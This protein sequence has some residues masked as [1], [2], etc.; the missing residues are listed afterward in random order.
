MKKEKKKEN[1][2]RKEEER[3]WTS[4]KLNKELNRKRQ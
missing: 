2:K 4:Q 3:K 1:E